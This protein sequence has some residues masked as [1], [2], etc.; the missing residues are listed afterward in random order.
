MITILIA[1][2]LI[3]SAGG[4]SAGS[5]REDHGFRIYE[6]GSITI[7]E[8]TGGPRFDGELFEYELV[9]EIREDPDRSEPLMY[10]PYN[11][12]IDESRTVFVSDYGNKQIVVFSHAGEYLRAFGRDGEGPGEFRA[13]RIQDIRNGV[14]TIWDWNQRRA[15]YYGTDGD[16]IGLR[17]ANRTARAEG[18]RLDPEGYSY[19]FYHTASETQS[20][21]S[22]GYGVIIFDA[23]DDSICDIRTRE[24][25]T[26]RI[27]EMGGIPFPARIPF[28]ARTSVTLSG[29]GE[30]IRSTGL[31]PLL[32]F[33]DR[34]GTLTRKVVLDLPPERV[35]EHE[36]SA[37]RDSLWA[38]QDRATS[39]QMSELYREMIEVLDIP[40]IKA[41][42]TNVIVD[43][44]GFIWMQ[45]VSSS[46]R[47][48]AYEDRRYRV[49]SPDGE[50]LG[51]TTV[52]LQDGHV[53]YGRFIGIR[54]DEESGL[55]IPSVFRI[56][57][58]VDGLAYP[59]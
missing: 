48:T 8:T 21:Q 42:W 51:D 34:D 1:T 37:I 12:W 44:N 39:D 46:F 11:V 4:C 54:Y 53:A 45:K 16:F 50:Y 22:N 33:F 18:I 58:I 55:G 36:R 41:F 19:H 57:P 52:P 9:T 6:E 43:S 32:E 7:A 26:V 20:I 40:G 38:I 24:V 49:L 29:Q 25:E 5:D 31:E 17:P 27:V 59:D 30:I 56:R 47:I 23:A 13:P 2:L 3:T 14:V 28:S 15:T 10:S 35:L